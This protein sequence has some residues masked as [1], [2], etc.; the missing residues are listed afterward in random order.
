MAG[1]FAE[2]AL[3]IKFLKNINIEHAQRKTYTY[4]ESSNNDT[5]DFLLHGSLC[6]CDQQGNDIVFPSGL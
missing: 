3:V 6:H 2:G 4:P 5:N 1:K